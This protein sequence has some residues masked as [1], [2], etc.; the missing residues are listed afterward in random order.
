MYKTVS[1]ES[2]SINPETMMDWKSEELLAIID[3]F[4]LK[5]IFTVDETVLF[6]NLQSSKTLTCKG[7]SCH[8]GTKSKQRVTVLLGCNADGTEKLPPLLIVKYSKPHCLRNVNK[9]T[10]IFAANSNS[11]MA[12]AT[13]EEFSV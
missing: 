6:R 3:G 12:T 10:T 1:G 4:Q 11:W 2:A 8:G 9:L 5:D 7:A 13:F